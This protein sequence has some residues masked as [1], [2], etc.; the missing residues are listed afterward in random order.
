[1]DGYGG[2]DLHGPSDPNGPVF[3]LRRDPDVQARDAAKLPKPTLVALA[4]GGVA[5]TVITFGLWTQGDIG[6]NGST[7]WVPTE[8]VS[9]PP[10]ETTSL[11]TPWPTGIPVVR[12]DGATVSGSYISPVESG[13]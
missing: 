3:S 7:K 11:T 1:M 4:P 2:I 13:A 6:S 5:H 9:T 12:D 10:N 8:I